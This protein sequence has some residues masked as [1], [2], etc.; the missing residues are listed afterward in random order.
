MRNFYFVALFI[1]MS[2]LLSM[3]MNA[4]NTG[5]PNVE[6]VENLKPYP[7]TI[8]SL[9]RYVILL[10]QKADEDAYEVELFA[11]KT[12]LV[13]CNRHGLMGSFDE[14]VVE[15]WGYTY[16]K[17]NSDGQMFSTMMACP[18]PKENKFVSG[19]PLMVRYNSRLPIVVYLPQGMELKYRIWSAGDEQAGEKK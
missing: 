16:Y 15:G 14:D 6:G 9:E 18:G 17:F 19:Q 12:M 1:I 7:A 11:G 2:G 4:Q 13:D 5:T 8:D 10:D 3:N